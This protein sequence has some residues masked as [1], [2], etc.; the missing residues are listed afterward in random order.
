M[1]CHVMSCLELFPLSDQKQH[2]SLESAKWI[3]LT[4]PAEEDVV[5]EVH[6]VRRL[7]VALL[8]PE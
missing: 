5:V 7:V 1:T 6:A 2:L 3:I 4:L 8:G